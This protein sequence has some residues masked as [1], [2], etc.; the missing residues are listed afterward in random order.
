MEFTYIFKPV[1]KVV[2]AMNHVLQLVLEAHDLNPRDGTL[3]E[4]LARREDHSIGVVFRS[5]R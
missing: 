4:K 1:Q 2:N 5:R 3:P